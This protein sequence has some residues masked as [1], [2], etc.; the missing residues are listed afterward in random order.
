[1]IIPES[2]DPSKFVLQRRASF[3]SY[4]IGSRAAAAD[5]TDESERAV[6]QLVAH[7]DISSA[8]SCD[9]AQEPLATRPTRIHPSISVPLVPWKTNAVA[10]PSYLRKS[11]SFSTDLAASPNLVHAGWDTCSDVSADS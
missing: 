7:S 1:M 9:E 2:P 11:A 4:S 6:E 10:G 8:H 5:A 3:G